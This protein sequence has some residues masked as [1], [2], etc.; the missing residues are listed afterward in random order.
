MTQAFS[1]FELAPGKT[2]AGRFRIVKPRR[3]TG[4]AAAFEAE[5]DDG[6][7]EL[8]VFA[9][10]LF[11][12]ELFGVERGVATG[13]DARA[14][15]FEAARGGTLFLD[16]IG[17]MDLALQAKLLRVLQTRSVQRVGGRSLIS[18]DVRV[19]AATEMTFGAKYDAG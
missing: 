19:V 15:C 3:Q 4:L 6:P 16:E 10:S 14:G 9:P 13:V 12:A 17:D 5:S 8:L 18:L 1:L 2:L 7:C 11:E